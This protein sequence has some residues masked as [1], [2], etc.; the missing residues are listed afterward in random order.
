MAASIGFFVLAAANYPGGTYYSR[1]T[2]GYDW[3]HNFISSLFLPVALNG[4]VSSARTYAIPAMLFLSLSLGLVFW[5][6]ASKITSKRHKLTI[7]IGGIGFSVY[8]FLAITP[9]HDL[10]VT[11]SLWFFLAA[12]LALLHYLLVEG[13][14]HFFVAGLI[15]FALLMISAVMYFGNIRFDLL[16][17]M[18]KFSFMVSAT[19]LFAMYYSELSSEASPHLDLER[20]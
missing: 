15:C 10:M 1:T 3:A 11:I 20:V 16:P 6:I 12:I 17:I 13:A 7:E 19:W 9:M 8:T 5:H 2:V 4:A 18:Q 14:M